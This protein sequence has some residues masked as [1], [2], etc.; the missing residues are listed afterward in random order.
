MHPAQSEELHYLLNNT[1]RA[2]QIVCAV[3]F[4]YIPQLYSAITTAYKTHTGGLDLL[5]LGQLFTSNS[6]T[7]LYPTSRQQ[8]GGAVECHAGHRHVVNRP[9]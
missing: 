2:F 6:R 5:L 4:N 8:S 9:P 7:K 3:L 1:R